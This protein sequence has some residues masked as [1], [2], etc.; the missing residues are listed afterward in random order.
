MH[1]GAHAILDMANFLLNFSNPF[2]YNCLQRGAPIRK[3]FHFDSPR[4]HYK[5]DAAIVWC[6]DHRFEAALRK[7]IKRSSIVHFDLIR[8]AGGAKSLAGGDGEADRQFVMEQVRKSVKLHGTENVVLMLH[9]DCGGYGGLA[10]FNHDAAREA[11]NHRQDLQRAGDF[12]Q[13]NLPHVNVL[14]YFVDFEGV[15]EALQS[16]ARELT[17]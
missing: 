2:P 12:V 10:A 8:V 17:A 6:F 14:G 9:S 1:S 3:L 16:R 5:C 15:W 13:A 7:L 4:E 11:E